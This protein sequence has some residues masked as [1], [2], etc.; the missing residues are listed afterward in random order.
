VQRTLSPS[1]TC[2]VLVHELAHELLHR[3]A[4]PDRPSRRVRETEAEA[5]AF[6]VCQALGL[7]SLAAS[8]DYIAL[9]QGD[10]ALLTRCLA[11][12]QRAASEILRALEGAV[13]LALVGAAQARAA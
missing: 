12:I 1:E 10:A 9:Y 8:R 7:S 13:P 2:S 3:E 6:V 11:R 5:V 4:V